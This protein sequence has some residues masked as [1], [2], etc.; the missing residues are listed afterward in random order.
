MSPGSR[1][2]LLS[3]LAAAAAAALG[4]FV[5]S[6]VFSLAQLKEHRLDL[7]ELIAAHPIAFTTAFMIVFAVLAA[8]APGA[9]IF[10]VAAGALYG[11]FGGFLISL[12]STLAAAT[13][14]FVAARYLLRS[15]G[16]APLRRPRRPHQPRLGAGRRAVP[17]GAAL[18]PARP[19]LPDQLPWA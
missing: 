19:L 18:Q 1:R 4:L 9:A 14:G 13:L 12:F 17:A 7:V 11:F 5:L 2:T 10:K 6:D 8:I 3:A 15:L 16:G